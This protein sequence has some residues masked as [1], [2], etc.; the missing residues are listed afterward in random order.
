MVEE[1]H[2]GRAGDIGEGDG[3]D[4]IGLEVAGFGWGERGSLGGGGWGGSV[5]DPSE[6]TGEE[7]DDSKDAKRLLESLFD[8]EIAFGFFGCRRHGTEL[9]IWI[10]HA[11]GEGMGN[12]REGWCAT[13]G[14]M[15]IIAG[16]WGLVNGG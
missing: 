6:G 10:G 3:G 12:A 9:E 5:E 1:G 4:I 15:R 2:T 16:W 7:C 14:F 13:F 8:D 11:I